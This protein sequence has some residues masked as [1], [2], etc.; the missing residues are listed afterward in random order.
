MPAARTKAEQVNR[1]SVSADIA[2]L[3]KL[4]VC[5]ENNMVARV[6]LHNMCQERDETDCSFRARLSPKYR[7]QHFK[8]SL[9]MV[10]NI[11]AY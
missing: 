7:N 8:N 9:H 10:D 4:I 6:T 11:H 5:E 1:P 2:I 3:L